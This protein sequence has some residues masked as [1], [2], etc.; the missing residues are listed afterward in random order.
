MSDQKQELI[1]KNRTNKSK[2]GGKLCGRIVFVIGITNFK[3]DIST[4]NSPDFFYQRVI[5]IVI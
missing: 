2:G 1:V 4:Y 5:E 3:L